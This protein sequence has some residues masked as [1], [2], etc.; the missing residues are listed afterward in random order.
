MHQ[1]RKVGLAVGVVLALGIPI[2]A[3]A[4]TYES[5]GRSSSPLG[6]PLWGW[7]D[8][9]ADRPRSWI[10]G[11]SYG[12]L[13][14]GAGPSKYEG[15]CGPGFGCDNEDTG[16]KI[17]TGGKFSRI[18]GVEAGYVYLGKGEANGGEQKAQGINVSLIANLPIGEMFNIYAK[19]GGIYGWTHT[20][21]SP[22]ATGVSTGN[23]HGLNWS[24]GAGVQ[25]DVAR[26]WAVQADWDHYRFDYTGRTDDAQM[27]SL[28]LVYKY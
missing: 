9:S 14:L 15:G 16:Y 7:D 26:N 4:Q 8:S 20:S 13:G 6:S 11:T 18:I 2:A 5:G 17:F 12:Y 22:L 28:N 27:Y 21:A 25:L 23:D 1:I 10:P 24:Y 19:G 3:N